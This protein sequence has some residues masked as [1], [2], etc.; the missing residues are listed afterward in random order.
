MI[1]IHPHNNWNWGDDDDNMYNLNRG[2]DDDIHNGN[3][4][5]D[6]SKAWLL[7]LALR[8]SDYHLISSPPASASTYCFQDH[9]VVYNM[10]A[11]QTLHVH[12]GVGPH[13]ASFS[14]IKY[15]NIKDKEAL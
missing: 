4:G 5:D 3:P 8:L 14:N 1:T 9:T 10:D 7:S 6:G 13:Q 12:N 15:I 2:N 11:I